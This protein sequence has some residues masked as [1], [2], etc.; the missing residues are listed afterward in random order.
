MSTIPS[1]PAALD[2][3]DHVSLPCRDLDE[4]IKFYTEVLGGKKLVHEAAF[5][6]FERGAPISALAR[7]DVQLSR[8][9]TN[10]PTSA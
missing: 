7:T 8:L 1:G 10:I 9:A 2:G 6:M 5:A 4:G 3:L